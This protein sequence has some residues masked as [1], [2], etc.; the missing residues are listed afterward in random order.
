MVE[1]QT[2]VNKMKNARSALSCGRESQPAGS[3]E[4]RKDTG[5]GGKGSKVSEQEEGEAIRGQCGMTPAH[6]PPPAPQNLSDPQS[7]A[8]G[9]R[10]GHSAAQPGPQRDPRG[11]G[12]GGPTALAGDAE[13]TGVSR[14]GVSLGSRR[15]ESH[16]EPLSLSTS[17]GGGAASAGLRPSRAHRSAEGDPDSAL[18]EQACRLTSSRG[19]RLETDWGSSR[20]ARTSPEQA[21]AGRGLLLPRKAELPSPVRAHTL[22]EVYV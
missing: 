3:Q 5:G 15:S 11:V 10:P 6:L 21:P 18:E 22:A 20:P 2:S 14:G 17:A 7:K 13:Q 8:L 16:M 1:L 9:N 12:L 4:T 19:S